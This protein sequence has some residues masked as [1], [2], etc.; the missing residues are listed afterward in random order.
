MFQGLWF[1]PDQ[2]TLAQYMMCT[3]KPLRMETREVS[4]F[5]HLSVLCTGRGK[6]DK[7]APR[8]YHI[9]VFK[10][11]PTL[12]LRSQDLGVKAL[13]LSYRSDIYHLVA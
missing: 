2:S 4:D 8:F 9:A 11:C 3:S 12:E 5:R 6:Y 7:L 10:Y 1:D 13:Y